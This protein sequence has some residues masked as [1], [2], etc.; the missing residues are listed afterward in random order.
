MFWDGFEDYGFIALA[1]IVPAL[2]V[3]GLLLYY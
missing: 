1:A 2:M 3:I